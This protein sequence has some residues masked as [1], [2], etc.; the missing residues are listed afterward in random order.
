MGLRQPRRPVHHHLNNQAGADITAVYKAAVQ[1]GISI[2]AAIA[3]I[4]GLT[5]QGSLAQQVLALVTDPIV[6]GPALVEAIDRAA[7]FY[8]TNPST[9]A[10]ISYDSVNAVRGRTSVQVAADH[11]NAI[12]VRT[13]AHMAA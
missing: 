2:N 5:G 9:L 13:S 11:L 8:G 7:A 4:A 1:L 10:H 6:G 12:A 3:L